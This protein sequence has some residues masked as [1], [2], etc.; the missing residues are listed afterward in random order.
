MKLSDRLHEPEWM[1]Q[2]APF[3]TPEEY[4]D[5][6]YKLDRVGRLL[7]GDKA[8]FW[9]FSKLGMPPSS[10]LDVGCGG[11]HFTI[12]LAQQYPNAKV[13]GIDVAQEAI[14]FAKKILKETDPPVSNVEFL[15]PPTPE[16][17]F[18]PHSFD[19][20]TS[21]LVC[22]HLSDEQLIS[23]LQRAYKIAKQAVILNDLH[24][25]Y[26]AT[27]G[28]ALLT[29]FLF[30]NRVVMHDGLLSIRRA[31]TKQ[32]WINYLQAAQIP[33]ERCVITW[34]W[35]FRWIVFINADPTGK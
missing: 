22:H 23:F 32:D 29:P 24:R 35:P 14:H 3:C 17:I 19:V 13:L 30:R 27:A 16:L 25:H 20:V 28:F 4:E 26:L 15:V 5:C 9:A 2:G 11:G 1:D 31:F 10:I 33:L 18:P 8:T 6:L 7:G 34:H 21:T 12:R